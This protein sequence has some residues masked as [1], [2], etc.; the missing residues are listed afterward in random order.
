MTDT[1]QELAHSGRVASAQSTY[2]DV[3]AYGTLTPARVAE[4]LDEW[5]KAIPVTEADRDDPT[6]WEGLES[7]VACLRSQYASL[8]LDTDLRNAIARIFQQLNSLPFSD[9]EKGK[10][11]EIEPKAAGSTPSRKRPPRTPAKPTDLSERVPVARALDPAAPSRP[12]KKVGAGQ[13]ARPYRILLYGSKCAECGGK[14][15]YGI[16][17]IQKC[18]PCASRKSTCTRT[19]QGENT[20]LTRDGL[21]RLPVPYVDVRKGRSNAIR[22]LLEAVRRAYQRTGGTAVAAAEPFHTGT[23]LE[24]AR[25]AE[26]KTVED[27]RIAYRDLE[28]PGQSH[29]GPV[30]ASA[31]PCGALAPA[32][33]VEV[34]VPTRQEADAARARERAETDADPQ[35]GLGDHDT[36]VI[37]SARKKGKSRRRSQKG[38]SGNGRRAAKVCRPLSPSPTPTDSTFSDPGWTQEHEANSMRR[39]PGP[40]ESTAPSRSP[41]SPSPTLSTSPPPGPPSPMLSTSPPPT[42]P[43]A[44]LPSGLEYLEHPYVIECRALGDQD[45]TWS[46][47]VMAR[48]RNPSPTPFVDLPRAERLI[49]ASAAGGYDPDGLFHATATNIRFHRILSEAAAALQSQ[50]TKRSPS[51]SASEPQPRKRRREL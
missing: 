45:L 13:A 39:S 5:E 3:R 9:Q 34:V 38:T 31:E 8:E 40:L 50:G 2:D 30:L 15:C 7:Q 21:Q 47:R 46:G 33:S 25:W 14:D 44:A 1:L 32:A 12:P 36:I 16:D 42:D 28:G 6:W 11:K 10:A 20:E 35:H 23:L 4:W 49:L 24:L 29:Y 22:V 17:G 26:G 51:P 18:M 19:A 41:G 43:R 48:V 27:V 37:T